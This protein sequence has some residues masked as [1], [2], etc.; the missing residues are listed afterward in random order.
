MRTDPKDFNDIR[1]V[2][3]DMNVQSPRSYDPEWLATVTNP[4]LGD[5]T[6]TGVYATWMG[7]AFVSC[8]LKITTGGAFS[9]G[10]GNYAITAPIVS[11]DVADEDTWFFGSGLL[12]DADTGPDVFIVVPRLAR[13]SNQIFFYLENGGGASWSDAGPITLADGDM[14]RFS[15]VYPCLRWST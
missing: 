10:S 1:R 14:M 5:S 13:N 8:C 3:A 12:Y 9:D 15:I 2:F 4:V 6:L 7:L 11:S